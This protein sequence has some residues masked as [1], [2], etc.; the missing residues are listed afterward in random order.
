MNTPIDL[1]KEQIGPPDLRQFAIIG[2]IAMIMGG[3]LLLLVIAPATVGGKLAIAL[4]GSIVFIVGLILSFISRKL[5]K[6]QKLIQK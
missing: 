3:I 6:S 1:D 5:M 4:T 2:S